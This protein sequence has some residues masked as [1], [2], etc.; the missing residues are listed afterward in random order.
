M[1]HDEDIV[2]EWEKKYQSR[3]KIMIR[4]KKSEAILLLACSGY[5]VKLPGAMRAPAQC[6]V[7]MD[8][9]REK[10]GVIADG[11]WELDS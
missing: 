3:L 4:K 7:A 1:I 2:K 6:V 5:A 11:R 10:D 9:V 8:E